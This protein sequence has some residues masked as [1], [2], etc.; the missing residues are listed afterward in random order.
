MHVPGVVYLMKRSELVESLQY[1]HHYT[2]KPKERCVRQSYTLS[3]KDT[4]QFLVC[5]KIQLYGLEVCALA[6]RIE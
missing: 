5:L 1:L 4:D 2:E 3:K 6:D